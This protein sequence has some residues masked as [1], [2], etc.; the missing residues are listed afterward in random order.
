MTGCLRVCCSGRVV[1]PLL[2]GMIPGFAGIF[3]LIHGIRR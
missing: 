3:N 2:P 1:F